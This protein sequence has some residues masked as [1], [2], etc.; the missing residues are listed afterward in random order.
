MRLD[1]TRTAMFEPVRVTVV[2]RWT[3]WLMLL[4][5]VVAQHLI[6]MAPVTA[7]EPDVP[8]VRVWP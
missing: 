3:P 2:Q 6:R 1:A 8:M 5:W 7:G 4:S